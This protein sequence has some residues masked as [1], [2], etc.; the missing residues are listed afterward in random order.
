MNIDAI[1]FV[2]R[3]ACFAA[4]TALIIGAPAQAQPVTTKWLFGKKATVQIPKSYAWVSGEFDYGNNDKTP[5]YEFYPKKS[6]LA[7]N[8]YGT[9]VIAE[10]VVANDGLTEYVRGEAKPWFVKRGHRFV[11]GSEKYTRGRKWVAETTYREKGVNY[12]ERSVVW[13]AKP[14]FVMGTVFGPSKDWNKPAFKRMLRV[15]DSVHIREKRL[16]P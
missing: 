10:G 3:K 6:N 12:R 7:E 15:L 11:R 5:S 16:V 14:G 8:S 9:F 13:T 4:L 1:R 2:A